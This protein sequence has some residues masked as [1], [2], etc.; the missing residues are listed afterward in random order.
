[1]RRNRRLGIFKPDLYECSPKDILCSD[2][3]EIPKDADDEVYNF[4]DEIYEEEE[5][6]SDEIY[7]EEE[8]FS[9]EIYEEEEDIY[10]S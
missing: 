6:F 9:D 3:K 2:Q 7:E 5:D 1:M 8:D 4:S 10:D